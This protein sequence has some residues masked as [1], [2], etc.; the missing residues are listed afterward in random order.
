M[1]LNRASAVDIK[2]DP[3]NIHTE[4]ESNSEGLSE[5]EAEKIQKREISIKKLAAEKKQLHQAAIAE[6]N[7]LVTAKDGQ[8][9][10][11][12]T[13]EYREF[14]SLL[15]QTDSPEETQ[16]ILD[17]IKE[18]PKKKTEQTKI[19]QEESLELN[20]EDPK[21]LDLEKTFNQICDDNK[22]LIGLKQVKGFKMW[23]REERRKTPTVKYLKE[24]IEKLEG[25]EISDKNGLAPRKEE[26]NK[27]D[28]IFKK[29]NLSSPL[30]S[31]WIKMEG[32]S[33]RREFR[34]NLDTFENHL[35]KIKDTGFYSQEAIKTIMQEML[36]SKNPS[37]Q[38][39]IINRA[40]EV[41]KKESEAFVHLDSTIN[42]AGTTIRKMSE[43]SKK[44]Y[45]DYYK[46]TNLKER[47]NLVTH[48]G[49]IVEH[50]AKLAQD[51]EKIY[52]KHP[53]QLKIALKSFEEL[54]YM[55][56]EKALKE[57]SNLIKSLDKKEDLEKILTIKAAHAKIDVAARDN[58]IAKGEEKTQG[59]YKKF[60]NNMDN[61]KNPETGKPGDL[62]ELKKALEILTSSKVITKYKN[63]AA[64]RKRKVDFEKDLKSLKELNPNLK[65]EE[66]NKWQKKYNQS[67]WTSREKIHKIELKKEL[68]KEKKKKSEKLKLKDKV[69]LK[70]SKESNEDQELN[71]NET[72]K[73]VQE[74]LTD[75]QGAEAM[76]VLLKYNEQDP[77]NAKILFWIQTV[78]SYMKE[79]GTGKK[80]EEKD[81][82]EMENIMEEITNSDSEI[83]EE[84]EEQQIKELNIEGSIMSEDRHN[85]TKSARARAEKES[86]NQTTSLEERLTTSAYEEMDDHFILDDESRGQELEEIN[87][88]DSKMKKEDRA[89]LKKVTEQ[90]QSKFDSKKG[91]AHLN[92]KDKDG[93]T[94]SAQEAKRLQEEEKNQLSKKLASKTEQKLKTRKSDQKIPDLQSKM[95]ALREAR[96]SVD[97]KS[98]ER[99]AL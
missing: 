54:D 33:E 35:D 63:L 72:I 13:K 61:F 12:N 97:K 5:K 51:L 25:K 19:D 81:S 24:I 90:E 79:F 83:Q 38:T 47:T 99:T 34:K 52:A 30:E 95:S 17:R 56:K 1:A 70:E 60:F 16:K 23:F 10:F 98:Q 76:K 9:S 43:A 14:Q 28:K 71:L 44:T 18:I 78:A 89:K 48:W 39:T 80:T 31:E 94:I 41:S 88:S 53:E 64:Y 67:S 29:Y 92:L 26:F 84:L 32:L 91:F 2:E 4:A 21:L 58:I 37:T 73:T 69:G 46:K 68:I 85:K 93:R 87:F 45:L 62:N 42:I 50:E 8:E 20:P 75:E 27:L 74:L 49:K 11:I 86:T 96:R 3:E 66:I 36:L 40:K 7:K 57:H 55:S 59:R 22:D 15:E 77:D 6:L 65:N 82:D